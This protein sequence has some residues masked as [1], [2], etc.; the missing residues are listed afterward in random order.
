MKL[1]EIVPLLQSSESGRAD[2]VRR[3]YTDQELRS[4]VKSFILHHGGGSEDVDTC[5][6]DMIVQ[7]IKTCFAQREIPLTGEL[8]PYLM[9]ILKNVWY[10]HVKQNSAHRLEE[11]TEKMNTEFVEVPME[12]MFLK[13]E[14]LSI[15][16]KTLS[17]LPKNCKEVLMYWA[18]G[19]SMIEISNLLNYKSE[20]MVRKKKSNCLS[21]L[22]SY[23]NNNPQLKKEL[24]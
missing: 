1:E 13:T 22:I 11:W 21:E 24:Y 2:W 7:F 5:Y 4:V 16:E 10:T 6:N 3:I 20:G 15:L 9:G 18:N 17:I 19:Y 12:N 8:K 14:K 23:V